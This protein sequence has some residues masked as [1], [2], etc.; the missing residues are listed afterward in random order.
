MPHVNSDVGPCSSLH[1]T[2]HFS[3]TTNVSVC[4]SGCINDYGKF[5][6]HY[7]NFTVHQSSHINYSSSILDALTYAFSYLLTSC[8]SDMFLTVL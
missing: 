1:N 5:S 4:N 3:D 2:D 8:S 7:E 6:C